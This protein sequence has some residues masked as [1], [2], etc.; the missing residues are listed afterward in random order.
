MKKRT[1]ISSVCL[2]IFA[3]MLISVGCG[4]KAQIS[5]RQLIGKWAYIHDKETSVLEL[6]GNGEASYKGIRYTFADDG[7]FLTL[8]LNGKEEMK[9]RYEIVKD[10][11]YL[12]EPTTY[13]YSGEE[14]QNGLVGIWKVSDVNWTLEFLDNGEFKEDGYFPGHYE[15]DEA[16]HTFKLMYNDHFEDTTCYYE[17]V[18]NELK[19][20]YPWRMVKM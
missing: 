15:V 18:G 2:L 7:S 14:E 17:I 6:S 9:L 16:N 10:D 3:I 20:E 19:V 5:N 13:V 11:L 12:Y 1:L 4:N 8:S